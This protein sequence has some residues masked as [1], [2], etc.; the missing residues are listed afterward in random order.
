MLR[1]SC[2]KV[3]AVIAA[4]ARRHQSGSHHQS[5]P[6]EHATVSPVLQQQRRREQGPAPVDSRYTCSSAWKIARPTADRRHIHI[7]T[8]HS[9]TLSAK[10]AA[11]LLDRK[12]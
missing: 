5:L 4:D 11:S 3:D 12:R 1:D 8:Q 9:Q 2:S 7:K 6:A 10:P